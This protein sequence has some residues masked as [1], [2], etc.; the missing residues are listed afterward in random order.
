MHN[1][2]CAALAAAAL[3]LFAAPA[4]ASWVVTSL[5]NVATNHSQGFGIGGGQQV[6]W[7][8]SGNWRASLWSGSP[9]SWIDLHP[10]GADSSVAWRAAGGQQIGTAVYLGE[11]RASLWLGSA[12]SIID[13]GK[14]AL[15]WN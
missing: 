11:S 7:A 15:P 1:R 14:P 5:H 12:G 10:A 2:R 8:F 4:L 6:G 9:G 13:L 3:G